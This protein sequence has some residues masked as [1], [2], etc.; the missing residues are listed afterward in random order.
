MSTLRTG[1]GNTS[2]A[3]QAAAGITTTVVANEQ[4][5]NN[6]EENN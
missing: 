1:I 2:K 3:G 5:K 6:I 4:H